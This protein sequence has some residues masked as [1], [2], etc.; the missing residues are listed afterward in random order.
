MLP[1]PAPPPCLLLQQPWLLSLPLV[2]VGLI[3]SGC[4]SLHSGSFT[5][6]PAVPGIGAASLAVLGGRHSVQSWAAPSPGPAAFGVPTRD[7]LRWR[8]E[9]VLEM[10][11]SRLDPASQGRL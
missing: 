10:T 9:G 1:G 3:S 6:L 2:S 5:G 4:V 8:R 7:V 11:L